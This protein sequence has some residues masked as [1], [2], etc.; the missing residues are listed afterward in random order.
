MAPPSV[1]MEPITFRKG[2][3]VAAFLA[4]AQRVWPRAY[5]EDAARE[6]VG[7]TIN[8][9]AWSGDTL[10]GS[11]RVLTD[12]YF[13]STIPEILVAPEY[14]RRGIGAQL[15]REALAHAPRGKV[16]FG[17]QPQSVAFFDRIGCQRTLIGFVA[18][19]PLPETAAT[20]LP[21]S[22]P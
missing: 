20:P 11:V 14:Q 13:Y 18:S 7:R 22:G 2:I 6:A 17:A 1:T 9:G 19:A 16:A 15:M 21:T 3:D 8:V 4:L 10:V 12:G 5:S